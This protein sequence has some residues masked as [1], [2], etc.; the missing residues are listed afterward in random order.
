MKT[1]QEVITA[2]EATT[3]RSAWGKAVKDDAIDMLYEVDHAEWATATNGRE[4]EAVL[5][6]G[7]K[8][9][10]Q[11]SWG[12][13]ALCYDHQ[14]AAHYCTPSEFKRTH[15]GDRRPNRY[16]EWLDVQARAL[17]QAGCLIRKYAK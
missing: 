5:L 11:Y 14:I 6:N 2:I 17:G 7:A 3:P 13:C 12:G 15:G 8:D 10:N 16:E 9:W 1:V 4:L